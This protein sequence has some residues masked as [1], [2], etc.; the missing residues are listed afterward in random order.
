MDFFSCHYVNGS[1]KI[2]VVSF[3]QYYSPVAHDDSLRIKI[4]IAA[5][6]RL[7]S[8]ILMSVMLSRIQMSPFVKE[9][10]S[11]HHHIIW[12]DLKNIT[13]MFL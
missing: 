9:S 1:S 6:H 5:I 11:V 13:P 4:S 2:Q 3:D 7:T 12:T 8:S 10:V